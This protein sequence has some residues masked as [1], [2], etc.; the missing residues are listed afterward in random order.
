VRGEERTMKNRIFALALSA[1]LLALC[2]SA[3]AQQ[4]TKVPRVGLLRGR[5][6]ASGTSLDGVVGELRALGYV[7]GKTSLSSL[8]PPRI[9][10]IGFQL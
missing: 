6:S 7:D 4:P 3:D 5:A 10:S 1:L 9:S 2:V 8:D